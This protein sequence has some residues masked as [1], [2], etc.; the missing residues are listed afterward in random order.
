MGV[1]SDLENKLIRKKKQ[2]KILV[3]ASLLFTGIYVVFSIWYVFYN[4]SG[5]INHL[6][7]GNAFY[8]GIVGIFIMTVF[9]IKLNYELFM[10]ASDI[11][12]QELLED[13]EKLQEKINSKRNEI[14][15]K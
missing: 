11:K 3:N 2:Y 8:V 13:L 12:Y 9:R 7:I 4:L 10:I 5:N 14:F 1:K 15:N 6:I